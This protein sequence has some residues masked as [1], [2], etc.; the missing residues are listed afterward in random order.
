MEIVK[1]HFKD[2]N[3][4]QLNQLEHMKMLYEEWNSKINVISRKDIE[5]F[6]MHHVLHS[7]A[8][9]HLDLIKENTEVLD[10]GTGGGFPGIPLAIYYPQASFTLVDSISKKIKVVN[11]VAS[12]LELSNVIAIQER[13]E[14]ID[15]SFDL[16]ISR[17]V[18]SAL[19]LIK[20]TSKSLKKKG[21]FVFI[22]GGNLE[23]EKQSVLQF[24]PQGKWTEYE[25][26]GWFSDSFFETKKLVVFKKS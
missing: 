7:L 11:E 4:V 17:A 3:A 20:W 12:A 1:K 23:E 2:L 22:K 6:Y 15:Q 25:L 9:C 10:V 26:K 5:H 18:A 14:N 24:Y 21:A 8:I 19:Q 16:I 13:M